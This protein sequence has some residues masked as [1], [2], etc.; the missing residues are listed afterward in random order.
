MPVLL[1]QT[2]PRLLFLPVGANLDPHPQ[3]AR[4]PNG[5]LDYHFFLSFFA[6]NRGWLV[7]PLPISGGSVVITAANIPASRILGII[8]PPH[9][10]SLRQADSP[11]NPAPLQQAPLLRLWT[12]AQTY[13]ALWEK[14]CALTGAGLT[15]LR[16][17]AIFIRKSGSS[18]FRPRT[19]PRLLFL[20]VGADFDP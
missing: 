4:K 8:H 10:A 13:R 6:G 19:I 14:L 20:P 11:K 15:G 17:S 12:Q 3:K 9:S 1:T 18:V 2:P 16:D 5:K 7:H